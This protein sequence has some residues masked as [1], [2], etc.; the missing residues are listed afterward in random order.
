MES[1]WH[2][3]VC[4]G[5]RDVAAWVEQSSSCVRRVWGRGWC[6]LW[7]TLRGC[8]FWRGHMFGCVRDAWYGAES[9][10]GSGGGGA[11]ST[12]FCWTVFGDG[13]GGWLRWFVPV[14][15]FAVG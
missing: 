2:C 12:K 10:F 3:V 1:V 4:V 8:C 13:D 5:K 9:V 15:R 7:G 6:G 11:I 14:G